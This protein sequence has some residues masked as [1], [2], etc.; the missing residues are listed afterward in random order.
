MR[1]RSVCRTVALLVASFVGITAQSAEEQFFTPK[2]DRL[3]DPSEAGAAR[4]G[5]VNVLLIGDSIMGGYFKGVQ[6]ELATKANVVRHPGNAGDTKNGLKR[7][8]EWLGDTK[9]DVIHFNWGLHDLCYRHPESK[10]Q[11][12]RDKVKG[13]ISVPIEEYEKN[14]ETLVARL[15]KTG[16]TLIFATTTKVPEGEAGRHAGDEVKYNEV[17]LRVIKRHGI[18]VNDL[19]ALSSGFSADKFSKPGDVHFSGSGC[20]ALAKQVAAAIR[21]HG[22]GA[23]K[24]AERTGP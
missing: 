6:K 5:A 19:H 4:D 14:L 8:D 3:K 10:V 24:P 15:E 13:T 2:R 16:A 17:A 12:N 22:L 20:T 18:P 11:G 7:L 23:E 9:W 21:E 1:R